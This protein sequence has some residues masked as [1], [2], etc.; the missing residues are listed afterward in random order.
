MGLRGF[1][2]AS[3]FSFCVCSYF[4]V[5]LVNSENSQKNQ[6]TDPILELKH[7]PPALKFLIAFGYKD[8]RPARF[9]G[10]RYER[11][12]LV[13][14]L[15][16]PCASQETQVCGFQ[17]HQS[18][19]DMFEK[20]IL[21][22]PH[23]K[24]VIVRIVASSLGPDD[25]ENRKNPYQKIYSQNTK[26]EFDR[27][28]FNYDEVFYVGHSRDGG[29]PD[30]GPPQLTKKNHVHYDWYIK[31][32][33]GLRDLQKSLKVP[34]LKAR[35]L[36]LI[37]CASEK[38]FKSALNTINPSIN[39]VTTKH[40]VYYQDALQQVLQELDQSIKLRLIGYGQKNLHLN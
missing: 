26:Q 38:Q 28:L 8:A 34:H 4:F 36:G 21:P 15:L 32:K 33:P 1:Q 5:N 25:E 13:E 11:M 9:V 27:G 40:L 39:L 17:R 3:L 10:D 35:T 14:T 6:H 30:F 7:V 16:K 37:S 31:E 18:D 29:G 2:I 19:A 20:T 23:E 22:A 12:S 24:K